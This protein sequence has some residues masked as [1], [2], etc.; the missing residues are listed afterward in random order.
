MNN[1]IS[2]DMV[3]KK[4]T[5]F[6]QH[7]LSLEALVHWAESA[8]Q[9]GCFEEEEHDNVRDAVARLGVADVRAFGL[10]WG[11]CE[12]LLSTLGYKARIEVAAA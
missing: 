5:D 12:A 8:M 7:R 1:V 4:L 2:R 10:T 6:L 3:A 9:D 11:D